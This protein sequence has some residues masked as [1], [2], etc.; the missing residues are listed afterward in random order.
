MVSE[1][2]REKIREDSELAELADKV[3]T[4]NEPRI[5]ER[6]GEDVAL[7]VPLSA[8]GVIHTPTREDIE[9]GLQAFGA[10]KH[11]DTDE[12]IERIYKWRHESPPR[13]R[14]DFGDAPD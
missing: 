9:R 4:E 13:P 8:S 1:A 3:R 12:L 5:L 2:K 14:I 6:N 7:I 11:I 10:W